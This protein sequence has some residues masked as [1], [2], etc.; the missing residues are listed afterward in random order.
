MG[1]LEGREHRSMEASREWL[2]IY[3]GLKQIVKNLF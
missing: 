3:S 1:K 2:Q